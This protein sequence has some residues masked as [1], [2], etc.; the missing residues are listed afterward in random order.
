MFG[1]WDCYGRQNNRFFDAL[2]KMQMISIGKSNNIIGCAFLTYFNPESAA[3]AQSVLH[4]KQTLPGVS[5]HNHTH[6][7]TYI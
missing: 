2:V 7:Y 5:K 3:T 6:M 4:E 1:V